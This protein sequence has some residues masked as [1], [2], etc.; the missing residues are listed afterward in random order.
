MP[1]P[2]IFKNLS[3]ATLEAKIGRYFDDAKKRKTV[4]SMTGLALHLGC[5]RKN[6][7]DYKDT[8][9]FGKILEQAKLR[10][11]NVLE[12][13]MIQGT[14]PTGIIFIL[15]NNYGW[16][17][18]IE[19]E[20]NLTGSISLAKLFDSAAQ[21]RRLEGTKDVII[22][23]EVTEAPTENLLFDSDR[24]PSVVDTDESLDS[25]VEYKESKDS[26]VVTEDPLPEELF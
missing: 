13:K 3:P 5:T 9:E 16:H 17:D 10:C 20:V 18:K 25:A 19:S 21:Q 6:L 24:E 14:P 7:T 26:V 15:K 4:V 2:T 22:D 12:E 11:E 1:E 8:D 23:G